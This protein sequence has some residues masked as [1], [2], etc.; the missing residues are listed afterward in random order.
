ME[1]EQILSIAI[2]ERN[3]IRFESLTD[4]QKRAY[5]NYEGLSSELAIS[6]LITIIQTYFK[7]AVLE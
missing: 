2:K 1:A 4:N 5:T 3:K 7:D 6:D